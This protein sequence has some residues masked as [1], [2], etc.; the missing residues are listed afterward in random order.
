MGADVLRFEIEEELVV[1]CIPSLVRVFHEAT[2]IPCNCIVLVALPTTPQLVRLISGGDRSRSSCGS[3]GLRRQKRLKRAS[4]LSPERH[5]RHSQAQNA[6]VC[7]LSFM[8]F[9]WNDDILPLDEKQLDR[10]QQQF[11]RE[12]NLLLLQI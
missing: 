9:P 8:C 5:A 7:E 6:N 3:T 12:P 10:F 1:K 2:R 11:I 4:R